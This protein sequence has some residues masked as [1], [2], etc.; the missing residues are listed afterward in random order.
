MNE[1]NPETIPAVE[2]LPPELLPPQTAYCSP[3]G[4][5]LGT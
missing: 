3:G 2:V 1:P 4:E 5:A